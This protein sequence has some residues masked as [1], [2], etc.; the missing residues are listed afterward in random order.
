MLRITQYLPDILHVQK[1]LFDHFHQRLDQGSALN[2]SIKC[3]LNSLNNGKV[4]RYFDL[5][6][7]Y[8]I[9]TF[10]RSPQASNVK[11]D[12]TIQ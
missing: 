8:N 2:M 12:T 4:A 10:I 1:V 9:V 5:V 11:A 6:T 7:F 3:Y